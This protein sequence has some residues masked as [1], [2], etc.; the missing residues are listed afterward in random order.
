MTTDLDGMLAPLVAAAGLGAWL[1][2]QMLGIRRDVSSSLGRVHE[3]IDGLMASLARLEG[4]AE[5]ED[6]AVAGAIRQAID[7]HAHGC[8]ARINGEQR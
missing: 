8:P 7:E 2:G 3:R 5:R 1:W 4:R 6:A